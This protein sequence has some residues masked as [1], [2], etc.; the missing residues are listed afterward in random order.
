M[1]FFKTFVRGSALAAGFAGVGTLAYFNELFEKKE[2]E[3]LLKE[4]PTARVRDE[5]HLL[6]V[7]GGGYWKKV[8]EVPKEQPSNL[9]NKR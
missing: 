7:G 4:H 8:V 9:G 6:P 5:F 2:L 1:R 3:R